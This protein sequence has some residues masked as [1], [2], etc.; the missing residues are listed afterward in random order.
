[1]K[2]AFDEIQLDSLR[3]GEENGSSRLKETT[4]PDVEG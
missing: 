4:E 2:K 3:V 1:M